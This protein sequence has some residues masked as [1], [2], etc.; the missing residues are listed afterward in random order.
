MDHLSP[1]AYAILAFS[2]LII[3]GFFNFVSSL[4]SDIDISK[5]DLSKLSRRKKKIKKIIYIIKNN[6]FLFVGTSVLSVILNVFI[7]RIIFGG[8]NLGIELRTGWVGSVTEILTILFLVLLTEILVRYLAEKEFAKRRIFNPFLLTSAHLITR[9]VAWPLRWIIKEKKLSPYREQDLIRLMSNLEAEK[10]LE[11]QEARLLRAA[12]N[13]DEETIEKHF[14]PRRRTIFLSTKMTFKE[15][16][17]IYHKYRYTRYPVLSEEQ[18]LVGI[19][20]FKTLDLEMKSKNDDWQNFIEK[21]I[22]YLVLNT[23]LN[24]A[25][26]ACQK[27]CQHLAAVVN[28]QNKFIG[29]I[30]LEDILETLVGEI[31]D[32]NET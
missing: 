11:P 5:I 10:I 12:F 17:Q 30:T 7:S 15:I 20:N 24:A 28:E 21:K 25:F 6:Y 19:L 2:L 32:E 1:I 14:K 4:Y 8:G 29:I 9:I 23:K 31:K 18:K 16:Q 3:T 13:F 26:E 22:N 27:Y